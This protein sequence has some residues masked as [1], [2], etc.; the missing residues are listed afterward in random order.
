MTAIGRTA[1]DLLR[2]DVR[3]RNEQRT[4]P[5][6]P[7]RMRRLAACAIR[8]LK[9]SQK[10]ILAITF[11]DGRRMRT[12]NRRVLAHNRATDVITLRYDRGEGFPQLP[13]AA[14]NQ[15]VIGDVVVCPA[16]ASRYA[17]KH[18]VPYARELSRYVVH[19]ILH[20][21]GLKDGAT[22]EKRRMRA[23]EERLLEGCYLKDS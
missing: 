15:A 16:F 8:K 13:S 11:V 2:M 6:Y 10:G 12:F 3:L 5:V 18:G 14:R 19:G 20:W 22:A 9:L 23:A 21:T 7:A 17:R 1:G 4:L